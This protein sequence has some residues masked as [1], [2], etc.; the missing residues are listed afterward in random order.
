M[1]PLCLLWHL[2]RDPL[3]FLY[4][5]HRRHGRYV[6]LQAGPRPIYSVSEPELIRDVLVVQGE[7]F[8][9]GR[10]LELAKAVIGEGILTSEGEHHLC[11]RRKLQPA[12]QRQRLEYDADLIVRATLE[13][14]QG[15]RHGQIRDFY[16]EMTALSL[17]I[18][19]RILFGHP[20][21]E[22]QSELFLEALHLTVDR[23]QVGLIPIMGLVE[24]LPLKFNRRFLQAIERLDRVV[25]ELIRRRHQQGPGPDILWLLL[26]SDLTPRQLRDETMTMF[27]AGHETTASALSWMMALLGTHP[28]WAQR[29]REEV[30]RV[31]GSTPPQAGDVAR[32]KLCQGIWLESMRLYPPAWM[33]GRRCLHPV[34]IGGES[35]R[36]G[37]VFILSQWVTHRDPELF[38]LSLQFC[39]QRWL[40][41]PPPRLAYFPFGAGARLC[42]GEPLARL[43]GTLILALLS[44]GWKVE[45]LSPELPRPVPRV[46]LEPRSGVW[47]RLLRR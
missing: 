39:P 16:K 40:G 23:F 37:A 31:L 47:L 28:Q 35:V 3:D 8:A 44:Q 42:I 4:R 26:Q 32:L 2:H 14:L 10:G 1:S 24:K 21:G 18:M 36:A 9:K 20:L 15:W 38:P 6:A 11:Q 30:D 33:M 5:L 29:A 46:T 45:A 7:H 17:D 27:L 22:Q 41:A 25:D 34:T 12:F 43:E 13:R 19:A